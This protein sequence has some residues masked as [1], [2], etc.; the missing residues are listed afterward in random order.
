MQAFLGGID[1]KHTI[2]FLSLQHKNG[3]VHRDIKAE[4]IFLT[5]GAV[6]LG[7]FGFS[8]LSHTSCRLNTSCGSIP[9]AAPELFTEDDYLG[10]PVDIWAAGVTLYFMLSGKMPFTGSS[11]TQLKSTIAKGEFVRL[12]NVSPACEDL[13]GGLLNK[14]IRNR[15]TVADVLSSTWL[16]DSKDPLLSSVK[17]GTASCELT[18]GIDD[19]WYNPDEEAVD[20]EVVQ[21]LQVIGLPL[22]GVDFLEEPRNPTIGTYRILLHRKRSEVC[23]EEVPATT[24]MKTRK[25]STLSR[26]SLAPVSPEA[27]S[28]ASH[29]VRKIKTRAGRK[30]SGGRRP[31]SQRHSRFCI[32]L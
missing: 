15:F 29:S 23:K 16:Q 19:G 17:S 24:S 1:F 28:R 25:I 2:F 5:E 31:K 21:N 7:D 20:P 13:I 8:T 27:D 4:N 10:Q 9:Y 12:E 22:E 6:K 3:I 32:I 30:V 11:A 18:N 26:H 14:N